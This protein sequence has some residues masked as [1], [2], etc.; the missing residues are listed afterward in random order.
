MACNEEI[1]FPIGMSGTLDVVDKYKELMTATLGADSLY[2]KSKDTFYEVFKDLEIDA[3][4]K[5]QIVA[6]SISK[7]AIQ[8]S[9]TAMQT[10][11]GWSKEER[12]GYYTTG[13]TYAQTLKAQADAEVSRIEVCKAEAEVELTCAKTTSTLAASIRENGRVSSWEDGSTC[14]PLT[15]LDENLKYNQTLMVIQQTDSMSQED[16]RKNAKNTEDILFS[17]RQRQSFEDS[18]RNH[19][20][21]AASQMISGLIASEIPLDD[22]AAMIAYWTSAM[23]YLTTG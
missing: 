13:L 16:I 17:E 14:K 9:S 11:L 12:D 5:A 19:A 23:E 18:K 6:E 1:N 4:E 3:E 2:E 20:A 8:M 21:N 10:A 15:L 22:E 7:M